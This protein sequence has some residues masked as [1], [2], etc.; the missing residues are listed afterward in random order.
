MIGTRDK[1]IYGKTINGP[2]AE[3]NTEQEKKAI[4]RIEEKQESLTN[5]KKRH[6]KLITKDIQR[7]MFPKEKKHHFKEIFNAEEPK[8]ISI[9]Y[10]VV[11]DLLPIRNNLCYFCKT[12][13]ESIKHVFLQCRYLTD[14]RRTVKTYLQIYNIKF[15]RESIIDKAEVEK[16]LE[17]QIISQYK[18]VIWMYRNIAKRKKTRKKT[19]SAENIKKKLEKELKFY[20][21]HILQQI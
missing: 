5:Y 18:F 4:K 2:K 7:I 16:G 19:P 14:I 8:L 17:N 21:E 12:E 11:H 13:P 15:D 10:L 1:Q 3:S 9:N 20:A 6:K